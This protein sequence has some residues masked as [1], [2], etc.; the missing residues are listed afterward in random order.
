M[1]YDIPAIDFTVEQYKP[2]RGDFLPICVR[3]IAANLIYIC[4][5]THRE[6]DDIDKMYTQVDRR[7]NEN[8]ERSALIIF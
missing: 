2:I 3:N 4:A 6:I 7:D 5:R 1:N 8:P